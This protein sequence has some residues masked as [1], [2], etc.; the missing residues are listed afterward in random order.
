[1]TI[2]RAARKGT[3]DATIDL[4][5]VDIGNDKLNEELKS[6]QFFDTEKFPTATYK[7]TSMK[8][9]WRRA[10]RCRSSASSIQLRKTEHVSASHAFQHSIQHIIR[11]P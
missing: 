2:D 9:H 7:G 3:L 1:V 5:S 11:H 10:P 4:A 8:F 6:A